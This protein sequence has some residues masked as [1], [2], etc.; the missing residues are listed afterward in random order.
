MWGAGRRLMLNELHI[1]NVAVIE[2]AVVTF[3]K[4]FNVLT[5]ETGAGKSIL[6]D[7]INAILGNRTTRE[8]VRTGAERAVIWA[9]FAGVSARMRREMAAR[10]YGDAENLTLYREITAD[11]RSNCRVN[12]KSATAAGVRAICCGLINIHGQHDNQDLLNPDR[13]IH[14]IDNFA[15]TGALLSAYGTLYARLGKLQRSI[16]QLS[17]GEAEKARRIDLL[18]YQIEEIEQAAPVPGEDEE[19][20]ARRGLIRNAEKILEALK[21]A[22]DILAGGSDLDGA[23]TMIF[24]ASGLL[25]GVSGVDADIDACAARMDEGYYLLGDVS[26]QLAGL[27]DNLDYNPADL[28]QIEERLDLIYKLKR[29]YGETIPDVL[30]F[31][32]ACREELE[33]IEM[34]DEMLEQFKAEYAETL[35]QANEQ[36]GRISQQR[37]AAF[38]RFE[39][40]IKDEL[41]YLNM[42]N[43]VFTVNCMQGPLG[44]LGFDTIEFYISTN[45]GEP[46]KPLSKIAS[47]GELSRIMLAIKNAMADKDDIDTLIFDEIDTG[48]S[49][50]SA[51][52]IGRKLKESARSRQTICVTHSAQVA[53][54]ADA[55]LKIEKTIR[56]ARTYTEITP[57][58]GSQ[59]VQELARIISGDNVTEK[60]LENAAEMMELAAGDRDDRQKM[61][62]EPR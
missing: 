24:S 18:K 30:A 45:I 17:I 56:G 23:L 51:A 12:G 38:G 53:A 58:K 27:L 36:A 34:S 43:V 2:K 11:G 33:T 16:E 40:R 48:I 22:H 31:L 61:R 25:G 1:E 37:R 28:E 19:L 57:L 49:G 6:I 59:R 42:P 54:Y 55:H 44:R 5:G 10:G 3:E 14:V 13:H 35:R 20:S 39:E 52:R 32:E 8:I 60:A 9:T 7:S 50:T 21:G 47:G 46:P 29:K 26:D 41:S 62:M 15:E 4:G